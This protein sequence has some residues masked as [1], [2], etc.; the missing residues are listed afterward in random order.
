MGVC[1]N[2]FFSL[3]LESKGGKTHKNAD[4]PFEFVVVKANEVNTSRRKEEENRKTELK[5]DRR[6][7][8]ERKSVEK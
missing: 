8:R 3:S 1:G 7:V 2:S 5:T 4:L 6:R